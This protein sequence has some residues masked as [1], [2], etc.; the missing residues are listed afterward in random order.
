V[1]SFSMR[2][3]RKCCLYWKHCT[4]KKNAW[5]Q[6]V[7]NVSLTVSCILNKIILYISSA[8]IHRLLCAD[9]LVYELAF[10]KLLKK[11]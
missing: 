7:L 9:Q 4:S 3:K 5:E 6:C 10:E 11:Q 8:F 2:T 1:A